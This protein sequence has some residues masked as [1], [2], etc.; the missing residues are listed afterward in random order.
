[1]KHRL[2]LLLVSLTACSR[3]SGSGGWDTAHEMTITRLADPATLNPLFAYSQ[4]DIDLTQLYAEPLVG[5]SPANELVPIVAARVP[6]VENGDVSHDGL[7]ITY[8]SRRDI[9]G[10]VP[11]YAV[12]FEKYRRSGPRDTFVTVGERLVL[13]KRAQ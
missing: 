11:A 10:V 1:M 3:V 6:T 13:G 5:S 8:H 2:L 7:T 12:D 4:S 9:L